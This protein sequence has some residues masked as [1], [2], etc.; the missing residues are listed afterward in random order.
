[1]TGRSPF[2]SAD[3]DELVSKL[4]IEEKIRLL[5]A[6]NWWNTNKIERLDVPSV[7]MSDGPNGVRGSSHFLSSPAQC[8]PVSSLATFRVHLIKIRLV[9]RNSSRSDVRPRP[10]PSCRLFPRARSQNQIRMRPP[11][12][13]MQYPALSS[14]RTG[15]R[16]ILRGPAPVGTYGR[17]ICEWVAEGRCGGYD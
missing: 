1:M 12:S 11:C 5:G 6:P 17:C 4:T 13:D 9:V 10:H 7:R 8:I 15:L 16:V 2:L 3:I 14:W